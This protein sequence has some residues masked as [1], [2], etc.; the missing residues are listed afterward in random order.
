MK[1]EIKELLEYA[2][3]YFFSEFGFVAPEI[4]VIILAKYLQVQLPFFLISSGLFYIVWYFIINHIG[5]DK[6]LINLLICI[7]SETDN[8]KNILENDLIKEIKKN[9]EDLIDN[10]NVIELNQFLINKFRKYNERDILLKKEFP[11]K[12]I[13]MLGIVKKREGGVYYIDTSLHW[14][15]DLIAN[16][17]IKNAYQDQISKYWPNYELPEKGQVSSFKITSEIMIISIEFLIIT[18]FELSQRFEEALIKSK[19]L[20]LKK[21]QFHSL[22]KSNDVYN[23][24]FYSI[25]QIINKKFDYFEISKKEN[26]EFIKNILNENKYFIKDYSIPSVHR[27]CLCNDKAIVIFLETRNIKIARKY[28]KKIQVA[29]DLKLISSAF[30]FAYGGQIHSCELDLT[31]LR[32]IGYN[33]IS[34]LQT[35]TF[36]QEILKEN[37]EKYSLYFY[38]GYLNKFFKNDQKLAK[39]YFVRY[40]A[41]AEKNRI[42]EKITEWIK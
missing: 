8:E 30:L 4:I 37:S 33:P 31:R 40:L 29:T 32:K 27:D 42:N 12:I 5:I 24:I 26:I 39:E 21:N 13:F 7:E 36:A 3:K 23:H 34:I 17:N 2:E 18:I 15:H 10:V 35:E 20:L 41:K 9:Y 11:T 25:G 14:N 22:L 1:S 16:K 6:D 19:Q 38:L 28:V